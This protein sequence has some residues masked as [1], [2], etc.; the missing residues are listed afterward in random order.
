MSSTHIDRR[1]ENMHSKLKL[2]D[3]REPG[4]DGTGKMT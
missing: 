1:D 4:G 3:L 2:S